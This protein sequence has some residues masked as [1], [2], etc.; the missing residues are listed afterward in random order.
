[1]YVEVIVYTVKPHYK[2]SNNT[3][4]PASKTIFE[5]PKSSDSVN[6][7]HNNETTPLIRPFDN[8]TINGLNSKL[9]CNVVMQKPCGQG[10]CE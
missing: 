7:N 6:F 1:M 10:H 9:Y 8:S 5:C 2:T 4:T 3:T